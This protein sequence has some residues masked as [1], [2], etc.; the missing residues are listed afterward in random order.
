MY[1]GGHN[2]VQKTALLAMMISGVGVELEMRDKG[3]YYYFFSFLFLAYFF[4][5]DIL[6][7]SFNVFVKSMYY[8]LK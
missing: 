5:L 8:L 2:L 7:Y 3:D 1:I 4:L 6:L